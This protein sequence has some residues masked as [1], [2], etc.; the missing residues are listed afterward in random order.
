MK[1][2]VTTILACFIMEWACNLRIRQKQLKTLVTYYFWVVHETKHK[3]EKLFLQHTLI[4]SFTQAEFTKIKKGKKY[5][6]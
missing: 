1:E 2:Q 4:N 5:L 6:S 3:L